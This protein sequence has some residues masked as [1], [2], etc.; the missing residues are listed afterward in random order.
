MLHT[1]NKKNVMN[2]LVINLKTQLKWE[3][4]GENIT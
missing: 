2:T 3:I 4:L 1:G